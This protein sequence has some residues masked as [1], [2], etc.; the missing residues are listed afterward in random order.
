MSTGKAGAEGAPGP[1]PAPIQFSQEQ[2]D[3]L[4]AG[5]DRSGDGW[6]VKATGALANAAE[7]VDDLLTLAEGAKAAAE[8][9]GGV[10]DRAAELFSPGYGA[11]RHLSQLLDNAEAAAD[12]VEMQTRA[13]TRQ[14]HRAQTIRAD[15]LKF[16]AGVWNLLRNGSVGRATRDRGSMGLLMKAALIGAVV[17]LVVGVGYFL[18]RHLGGDQLEISP[19]GDPTLNLAGGGY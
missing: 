14:Q 7:G 15:R 4:L 5:Q 16:A 1:G 8:V 10:V 13:Y 11:K 12:Q 3:R 17:L 19:V 6:L 9:S 2:F 18:V